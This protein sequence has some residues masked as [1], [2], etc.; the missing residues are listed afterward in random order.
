M[1]EMPIGTA[2][3]I[4]KD[5]TGIGKKVFDQKVS[6]EAKKQIQEMIDKSEDLYER[7]VFLEDERQSN[8]Q[9]ISELQDRIKRS[10]K[11][12]SEFKKYKPHQ[13][14]SNAFV[15][16]YDTLVHSDKPVHHI[17]TQCVDE[18]I[19]SILQPKDVSCY[20]LI[21]HKCNS[22]YVIKSKTIGYIG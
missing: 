8:K 2:W 10:K 7:I 6:D 3:N 21:C 14:E 11:F 18:S 15:Y 17:C 1:N 20:E 4:V 13:L 19:I 9:L 5:I 12:N 22:N 16:T